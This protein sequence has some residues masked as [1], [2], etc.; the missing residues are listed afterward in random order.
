MPGVVFRFFIFAL[1]GIGGYRALKPR[2]AIVNEQP[3]HLEIVAGLVDATARFR[4]TTTIILASQIFPRGERNLGFIPWIQDV[5]C[6]VTDS[7]KG[8]G[9]TSRIKRLS[10]T[11]SKVHATH[12]IQEW[13]PGTPVVGKGW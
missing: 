8:T 4:D 9:Y 2:I 3:F 10:C 6:E 12:G 13:H 1:S 11:T 5:N 7:L